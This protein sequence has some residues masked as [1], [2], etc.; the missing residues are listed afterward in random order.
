MNETT[1]NYWNEDKSVLLGTVKR[2][3][4][5]RGKRFSHSFGSGG[6]KPLY[7]LWT[8]QPGSPVFVVEGEK[9]VDALHYLGFPC[10]SSA[11]GSS[12]ARRAAWSALSRTSLVVILPDYDGPGL[13]YA[14][15]VWEAMNKLEVP[16]KVVLLHTGEKG[17]DVYDWLVALKKAGRSKDEVIEGLSNL[18]KKG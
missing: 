15:V 4:G 13:K 16:V 5:A 14:S 6:G 11:C 12:A 18:L 7:G 1:Y 17:S 3:E 2:Y 8:V 10:V 9:C